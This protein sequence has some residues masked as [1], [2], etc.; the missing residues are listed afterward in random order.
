MSFWHIVELCK[1]EDILKKLSVIAII[2]FLIGSFN[3]GNFNSLLFSQENELTW[4][5]E[6]E[7]FKII[8]TPVY[9]QGLL[10]LINGK[11]IDYSKD[12][13]GVQYEFQ[14]KKK[15]RETVFIPSRVKSGQTVPDN[16]TFNGFIELQVTNLAPVTFSLYVN[17]KYC[18]KQKYEDYL[19]AQKIIFKIPFAQR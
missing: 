6:D 17:A 3:I 2:L 16:F 11:I 12:K 9:E 19:H 10:T 15:L 13:D 8:C 14:L 1:K 5:P 7:K 18:P 4:Q